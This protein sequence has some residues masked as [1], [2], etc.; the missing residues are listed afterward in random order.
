MNFIQINEHVQMQNLIH[1][2]L[3]YSNLIL[4]VLI[5]AHLHSQIHS[6]IY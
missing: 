1:Q 3:E 2:I 6:L 4:T 5:R